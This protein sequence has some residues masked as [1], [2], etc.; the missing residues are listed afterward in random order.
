[1]KRD[2]FTLVEV[3]M[4]V[5]I[6]SVLLTF[7]MVF[8]VQIWAG[9]RTVDFESKQQMELTIALTQAVRELQQATAIDK[10]ASQFGINPSKIVF[11]NPTTGLNDTLETILVTGVLQI[12]RANGSVEPLT[13]GDTPITE[14]YAEI[15]NAT[16]RPGTLYL[17]FQSRGITIPFETAIELRNTTISL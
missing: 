14:F 8:A 7:T 15:K 11:E 2:A 5:A 1:M 3:L 16:K 10:V 9:T 13:T 4:Y 6:S 12:R 17:R